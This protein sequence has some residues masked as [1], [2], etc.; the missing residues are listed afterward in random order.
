MPLLVF[1]FIAIGMM[2]VVVPRDG[3]SHWVGAESGFK[4]IILGT[5]AGALTPGGSLVGLAVMGGLFRSG[6][7]TGTLVA[8]MTSWSIW[9]ITRL[10]LEVGLLGWRFT[11]VRLLSTAIF[12]I[13]GGFVAKAFC[14]WVV[15]EGR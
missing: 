13:I 6:A 2:Q 3:L 9:G 12:P 10:P 1:E 11:L 8:F 15:F 4:G 7:G 14:S 5:I